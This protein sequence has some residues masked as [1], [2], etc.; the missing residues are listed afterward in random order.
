M[1]SQRWADFEDSPQGE[2]WRE[3]RIDE[4]ILVG[5]A[6]S[7]AADDGTSAGWPS[8]L[9]QRLAEGDVLAKAK[10]EAGCWELQA[11]IREGP[12]SEG[13]KFLAALLPHLA[14][15]R[16]DH[17]G[18][19]VIRCLLTCMPASATG[20]IRDQFLS[21][22]ATRDVELL[23]HKYGSRDAKSLLDHFP[24]GELR[25]L[26]D[27][28]LRH[29]AG[30]VR[31]EK[32]KKGEKREENK[33]GK[34]VVMHLFEQGDAET[35]S[36]LV[37]ALLEALEACP[38]SVASEVLMTARTYTSALDW[39]RLR[40]FVE[41]IVDALQGECENIQGSASPQNAGEG[42]TRR[43]RRRKNGATRGQTAEVGV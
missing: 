33:C 27:C 31:E 40:D 28:V 4:P 43:R 3:L 15:L 13:L 7:G 25:P 10:D 23:E 34:Y 5:N 14:E 18:N 20:P 32:R 24:L 9:P 41:H 37:D 30:L 29:A 2:V 6:P 11:R 35:R 38:E 42:K 21:E 26:V 36:A 12:T 16:E 19:H 39:A 17:C 22:L 1:G 8:G